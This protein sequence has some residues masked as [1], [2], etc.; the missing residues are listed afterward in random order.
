MA[1]EKIILTATWRGRET[2]PFTLQD[3]VFDEWFEFAF[4][5]GSLS[6]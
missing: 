5:N 3:L 6:L 4:E 1:S 2:L